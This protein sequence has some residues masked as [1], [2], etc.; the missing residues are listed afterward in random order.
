MRRERRVVA[1]IAVMGGL[2]IGG[3]LSTGLLSA[4]ASSGGSSGTEQPALYER[5]TA[6]NDGTVRSGQ[7]R[8]RHHGGRDCPKHEHGGGAADDA[9]APDTQAPAIAPLT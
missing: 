3:A 8:G 5:H 2:L 4:G 7:D 6:G 1:I 9:P